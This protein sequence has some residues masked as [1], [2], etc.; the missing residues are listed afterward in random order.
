MSTRWAADRLKH[1]TPDGSPGH[2]P[3]SDEVATAGGNLHAFELGMVAG[4]PHIVRLDRDTSHAVVVGSAGSGKTK[5]L[6]V[7]A[8]QAL[9][10]CW[11]LTGR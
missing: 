1:D 8:G 10:K 11:H 2:A 5:M 9:T 4:Q 7:L 3:A 6:Q